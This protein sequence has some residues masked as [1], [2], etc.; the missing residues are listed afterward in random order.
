MHRVKSA[1]C[2]LLLITAPLLTA[3][4]DGPTKKKSPDRPSARTSDNTPAVNPTQRK[5]FAALDQ[6]LESQKTFA[7]ENLRAVIQAHVADMLWSYDE[8]RARRLFEDALQLAERSSSAQPAQ[9]QG[10][11]PY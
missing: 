10:N 5:I 3:G 11:P 7:D 6:V 8:P 4:Q 1:A 2:I 9:A